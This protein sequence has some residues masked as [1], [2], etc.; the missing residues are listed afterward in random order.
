ML[1]ARQKKQENIA[2]YLLYMWQVED[3]IRACLLDEQRI[4]GLLVSRFASIPDVNLEEIRKWYLELRDMMLQE[5]KREKAHLQINDN[6]LIDLT[7]L[8]Q[9]LL[10]QGQDAI[11]TS[12]YYSTL[13]YIVELRS[14]QSCAD[15]EDKRLGELE[16]CFTALYGLMLLHM[17]HQTV[18]EQTQVAMK[19]ISKFLGLLSMKYKEWKSGELKFSDQ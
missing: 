14:K 16:T 15:G 3:L 11:Y 12:C 18:G 10:R 2:E 19:Q 7:D 1:I 9:H 6:I 17:Q 8:H 4:E 13:P 5:G